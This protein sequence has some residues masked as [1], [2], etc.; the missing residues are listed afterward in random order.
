[1][2]GTDWVMLSR[3]SGI[4]DYYPNMKAKFTQG[5]HF[6]NAETAG[7]LG[8]NSARFLGLIPELGQTG[9]PKTRQRL[10]A[11]YKANGLD[12]TVLASWDKVI[13]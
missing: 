4:G 12:N 2:Y 9:T 3:S 5:L 10:E 8:R 7:F 6:S 11:F 1:M 13:A